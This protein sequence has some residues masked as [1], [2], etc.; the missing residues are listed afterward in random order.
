LT[1]AYATLSS[2]PM[3]YRGLHWDDG[4]DLGIKTGPVGAEL[5]EQF[6]QA[7]GGPSDAKRI[8]PRR[9]NASPGRRFPYAGWQ[10]ETAGSASHCSEGALTLIGASRNKLVFP[11]ILQSRRR[12]MQKASA[13]GALP[14]LTERC[15]EAE[16]APFPG[17]VTRMTDRH[18]WVEDACSD[19]YRRGSVSV[20]K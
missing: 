4:R 12:P 20:R 5:F 2:G 9:G 10:D 6:A 13:Y 14:P 3:T 11:A 1:S 7:F 17:L 8:D 15:Q 18:G 19:P 16:S